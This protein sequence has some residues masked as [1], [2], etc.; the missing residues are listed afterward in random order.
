MTSDFSEDEPGPLLRRGPFPWPNLTMRELIGLVVA[1]AVSNAFLAWFNPRAAADGFLFA[2][3]NGLLA[4]YLGFAFLQA[5]VRSI[6]R[7]LRTG[8]GSPPG[9][10]PPRWTALGVAEGTVIAGTLFICVW[11]MIEKSRNIGLDA[12]DWAALTT[13]AVV[14]SIFAWSVRVAWRHDRDRGLQSGV[15]GRTPVEPFF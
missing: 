1:F 6:L 11:L 5:W 8:D 14:S 3:W 9:R 2:V 12:N 10:K 4:S 13:I 15:D 7:W